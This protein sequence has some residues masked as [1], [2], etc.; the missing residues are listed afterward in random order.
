MKKILIAS[1]NKGKVEEI[2]EIFKK[3]EIVTMKEMGCD[4]E[5]KE[6]GKTFEENAK[7]KA[8]EISKITN[9]PCIADDSGICIEVLNGW[10][11][12]NTAR[13]LG[14]GKSDR[15]R[16][17][18]IIEKIKSY[19]NEERIVKNICVMAYYENGKYI[20]AKGEL[21]GKISKK[22]K[23]NNGFGFDEIFELEDKR[24]L[25]QLDKKEKNEI[26]ARKKA[27]KSLENKL[28]VLTK[29]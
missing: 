9:M 18:A 23:G 13:F 22:V 3:Y 20:T 2:K 7:K 19:E 24:T 28:K 10:P 29:K 12:V 21:K 14:E 26:S 1:N 5:V 15:E 11:G 4:I 27:L 8:K 16:N 6:D 17:E 25:A